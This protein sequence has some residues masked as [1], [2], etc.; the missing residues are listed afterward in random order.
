MATVRIR[1]PTGACDGEIVL[2]A[3]GCGEGRSRFLAGRCPSCARM[4]RLIAGEPEPLDEGD[5]GVG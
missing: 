4:W 1:C 2:A 5:A 3:Q